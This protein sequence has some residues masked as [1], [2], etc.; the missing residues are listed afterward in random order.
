MWIQSAWYRPLDAGRNAG[1]IDKVTM[2][3][4]PP[5]RL[6]AEKLLSVA[7]EVCVR[8]KQ[9]HSSMLPNISPGTDHEGPVEIRRCPGK[10]VISS[11]STEELTSCRLLR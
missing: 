10:K 3:A 4:Q 11:R 5:I 9:A 1:G 2:N 8:M 7:A 6:A